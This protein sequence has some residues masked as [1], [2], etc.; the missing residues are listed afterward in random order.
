MIVM[1]N[2][3][4]F[5]ETEMKISPVFDCNVSSY[6]FNYNRA[7]YKND[8]SINDL[9]NY[10]KTKENI[11]KRCERKLRSTDYIGYDLETFVYCFVIQNNGMIVYS[12]WYKTK[13]EA[14]NALTEFVKQYNMKGLDNFSFNV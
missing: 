4:P 8:S 11:G 10:I 6:L 5:N 13:E 7:M 2:N 12:Q 1:I 14:D 9:I 3:I